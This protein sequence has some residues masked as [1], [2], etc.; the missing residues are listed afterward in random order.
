MSKGG[1]RRS[2]RRSFGID[3]AAEPDHDLGLPVAGRSTGDRRKLV[4]AGVRTETAEG[5]RSRLGGTHRLGL[6]AGGLWNKPR[7]IGF[8]FNS[9]DDATDPKESASKKTGFARPQGAAGLHER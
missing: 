7:S 1:K 6:G 8:Q 3:A 4:L 5:L 2:V 9:D